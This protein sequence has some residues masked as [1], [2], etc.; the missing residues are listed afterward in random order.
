MIEQEDI[1]DNR[2]NKLSD[3]LLESLEQA[4]LFRLVTAYFSLG[5]FAVLRDELL[6]RR[7]L[8]VRFLYGLPN[9]R[10]GEKKPLLF[11]ITEEGLV[12][13]DKGILAQAPLAR[14]CARWIRR[15]NVQVR[16]L[17]K[18]KFL[19]GKMY[20][21]NHGEERRAVVGSSNFTR[22]GMGKSP[23]SNLELNVKIRDPQTQQMLAAWFDGVWDDKD[24]VKNAKNELLRELEH[25]YKEY[26]PEHIYYKTLYEL[27]RD[28]IE[29]RRELDQSSTTQKLS[30]TKIWQELYEFQRH[31]VKSI[32]AK[33]NAYNGCIL[34]DSVGLGKTYT[35]LAVIKHFELRNKS[36]LVM[37]PKRLEQNWQQFD[38]NH[39]NN[40]FKQD[41]FRFTLVAHTDLDRKKGRIGNVPI[42]EF[43]W[44]SFDLIVVD[45][46]HNFRNE[47]KWILEDGERIRKG[48][49]EKLMNI[50][51]SGGKTNMLLLSA[52]PVN[53]SFLDFGNQVKLITERDKG[54]FKH[55]LKIADME[56]VVNQA[57]RTFENWGRQ[58]TADK[59]SLLEE[60]DV[61]F[62]N[63]L[64]GLTIARSR[65]QIIDFYAED[66]DRI[67]G[68][69]Q[70]KPP[71]NKNNDIDTE[72]AVRFEDVIEKIMKLEY[73]VH[74]PSKYLREEKRDALLQTNQGN[75]T[76]A[77]R[78]K[79]I[80]GLLLIILLKRL[81]SSV[82]SLRLSLR[83]TIDKIDAQ[84][85][86]LRQYQDSNADAEIEE[87][88]SEI[89]DDEALQED[90]VISRGRFKYRLE[91]L[92]AESWR[93]D[94]MAEKRKVED[95]HELAA[96]IIADRD[97]KLHDL[98]D[99]IRRKAKAKEKRKI[100][101]FT[102]YIDTAEYLYECVKGRRHQYD[103]HVGLVTGK[104]ADSTLHLWGA[105]F[106]EVLN[107]F[108]P[109]GRKASRNSWD[110]IDVLIAT[111]CISE[112]Q[113]LHD[114]DTVLNY[115]IHWNPVRLI[116]RL[117]RIDRIGSQHGHI[118]MHNFWPMEDLDKYLNLERRVKDRM[119]IVGLA[120]GDEDI[121]RKKREELENK[122]KETQARQ[123]KE[124]GKIMDLE[125][126]SDS[127]NMSDLTWDYFF[128]QLL[129]YLERHKKE[130]E[131]TPAGAYA[132]TNLPRT[133][134]TEG[135]RGKSVIFLLRNTKHSENRQGQN[136]AYPHYLM[137]VN[138]DGV[139][140]SY[141]RART[142][143]ELYDR[144]CAGKDKPLKSLCDAF[145]KEIG[146][147]ATFRPYQGLLEKAIADI[148]NQAEAPGIEWSG[149]DPQI[150]VKAA[151]EL[152]LVT[153]LVIANEKN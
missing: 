80:C 11:A 150:A 146:E 74:R 91:D 137:L 103:I 73:P 152:E 83:K 37:C 106:D 53:T 63:L 13:T 130:L 58:A 28:E 148:F 50:I 93:K 142:I 40:P 68:F 136:P 75:F 116:Q 56:R 114:C 64:R 19:H 85:D 82:D 94:L 46:S 99:I 88:Y 118:T 129:L 140:F 4:D 17:A 117:G 126:A 119:H 1:L 131:N 54:A 123:I 108:A 139:Q 78:E 79:N 86:Q 145:T 49:H 32:L 3:F 72:G 59:K 121:L 128:S 144:L 20:L 10:D 6:R 15:E 149:A 55:S 133:K 90:F 70:R 35:A 127:L 84:L 113:N 24:L 102:T 7:D 9:V 124:D 5:G 100:L 104:S 29:E 31:G 138:K 92:D 33:I 51:K 36:V 34:A 65:K 143:L 109:Q 25:C 42:D 26:S 120:G 57:Q 105:S 153:W 44:A 60:L 89:G 61:D 62:L 111:D 101:V 48:R 122:F 77:M 135:I 30:D 141:A 27:F 97:A 18:E 98:L 47:S 112:G 147:P 41:R 110:Q 69:P 16:T 2:K 125:E 76:Q 67:G 81:E 43:D 12:C 96:G 95:L 23:M 45:E 21:T 22:R 71:R 134:A 66:L 52:T 115:D 132:V 14:A 107:C 8:E 151:D 38:A 39:A 87:N